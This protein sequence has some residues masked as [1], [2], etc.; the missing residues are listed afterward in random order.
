ML[1]R[2]IRKMFNF[3]NNNYLYNNMR[4]INLVAIFSLLS[5]ASFAQKMSKD[6]R[7]FFVLGTLND[8]M[9]RQQDPRDS[10]LLDR[11]YPF[12][13]PVAT[14]IDSI[15]RCDYPASAYHVEKIMTADSTVRCNIFSAVLVKKM[16]AY[17]NFKPSGSSTVDNNP[18]LNNRPIL[19]GRLKDSIFKNDNE[20][21]AFLE[22]VYLRFGLPNDTAYLINMANSISKASLCYRLLQQFNC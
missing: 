7:T 9:G 21:L 18:S 5:Y 11:Y 1:N 3:K 19:T 16:N 22:G 4:F 20:K 6:E 8:Y 14:I 2:A 10:D 17:Y 13:T 15:L 12:E